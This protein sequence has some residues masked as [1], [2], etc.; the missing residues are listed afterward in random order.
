MVTLGNIRSYL[1]YDPETGLFRWLKPVGSGPSRRKA[2]DEAGYVNC[3]GYR[4]V[5][6][7][8]FNYRASR[9]AIY[10]TAGEWPK[11]GRD[12]DHINGNRDDDRLCNLRLCSRAQNSTNGKP[13]GDRPFR[14]VT[15][16]KQKGKWMAQAGPGRVNGK[17]ISRFIGYFDTPEAAAR[18]YDAKALAEYGQFAR[19]NFPEAT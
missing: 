8:G 2:G 17:R 5:R 14:G 6:I 11:D 13:Y 16:D 19:L 1:S 4:V 10:L 18:A 3:H 15:F 9:L 7:A 12:V